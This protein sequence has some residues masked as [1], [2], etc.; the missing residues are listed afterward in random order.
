MMILT[1]L[2][3]LLPLV[4]ALLMALPIKGKGR[5][6]IFLALLGG[7]LAALLLGEVLESPGLPELPVGSFAIS[8]SPDGLGRFF[9]LLFGLL[10]FLAGLFSLEY[11]CHDSHQSRFNGFYLLTLWALMGLSQAGNLFT[12]YL[13]YEA[14]TIAS[15][16]LVFHAGDNTSMKAA[17]RYLG[18][19]L[20]GA[21]LVLFGFFY[22]GQFCR[23]TD[24]VAGGSLLPL[25]EGENGLLLLAVFALLLGFGCKAGLLPLHHWLP[26]AHPVAPAPASAVLSAAITK[27]GVLGILRVLWYLTGPQVLAGSWVQRTMVLL[28]IATIF[29]GSMLAWREKLLKRRLA[30]SSVSQVSYALYG[31]FTLSLTGLEGALLQILFHGL[32]KTGLFLFAGAVIHRT[33]KTYVWEL[34]GLGRKMPLTF[35]AFA[36][37]SLSLVGIPP[38]AG[39]VSKWSLA[40]GGM[41]TL[42]GLGV[43]GAGVLLLSALLTAGYLFPISI[44]G[45]T[46]RA[47]WEDGLEPGWKMLLPL[48]LLAFSLLMLGI[49]TG[50]GAELVSGLAREMMG[51]GL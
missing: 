46:E 23:S 50:P 51:G 15:M 49:F 20:F 30:W 18:Y 5:D 3:L 33:G 19:S 11:N 40:L 38:F 2:P 4:G 31:I 1:L 16:P 32:C 17:L 22:L 6:A 9:G 13:F 12:F 7:N 10:F 35:L 34:S 25:P 44:H 29:T 42:G 28:A 8:L 37:L 14:M 39:F 21:A 36:L 45:W 41:E 24:F 26:V 43:A 27:A 47:Q 48:L